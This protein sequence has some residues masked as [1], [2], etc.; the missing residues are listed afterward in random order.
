MIHE[1]LAPVAPLMA[2]ALAAATGEPVGGSWYMIGCAGLGLMA[3]LFV[4]RYHGQLNK[5]SEVRHAA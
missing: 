3:S 2:T 4:H 5:G 1:S